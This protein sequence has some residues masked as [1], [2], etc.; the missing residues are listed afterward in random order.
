MKR[1][2][3]I[4]YYDLWW[5]VGILAIIRGAADPFLAIWLL[6]MVALSFLW[7]WG[8]GERHIALGIAPASILIA[9]NLSQQTFLIIPLLLLEASII[10]RIS[11][12]V[13]QRKY[14]VSVDRPLLNLFNAIKNIGDDPL[15]LCLPSV[16]SIPLAYF[17]EKKV[18]YGENSSREGIFFQAEVDD[19]LK[20]ENGVEELA[21]KYS[22]TH[23]FVD[24]NFSSAISSNHWHSIIQEERFDV[25]TRKNHIGNQQKL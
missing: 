11:I 23:L 5:C 2:A 10:V 22:V 18:L 16:Y 4:F 3:L 9:S 7:S 21:I 15:F 12:K 17:T 1:I 6:T 13:L 8:E 20:T 19:A 24:K 25:L 14:L